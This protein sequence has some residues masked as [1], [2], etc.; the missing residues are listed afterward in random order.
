[1][2]ELVRQHGALK[3]VSAHPEFNHIT[4]VVMMVLDSMDAAL[5]KETEEHVSVEVGREEQK[6][7]EKALDKLAK[8][9]QSWSFLDK[10]GEAK[11]E[12]GDCNT[13]AFFLSYAWEL[14]HQYCADL[15]F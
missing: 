14:L 8:E 10:K 1:M 6:D 9:V 5:K 15:D 4:T 11:F 7:Y 12:F 13:A 3:T 2:Y